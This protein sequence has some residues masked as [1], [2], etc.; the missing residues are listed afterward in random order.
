MARQA[1]GRARDMVARGGRCD[2]A[3]DGDK[4]LERDCR[5]GATASGS[6]PV[7]SR[8]VDSRPTGQAPPSRIS[9]TSSP[10]SAATCAAMVGLTRPER[11]ADG[12]AIGLAAARS[13]SCAT[14]WA[15]ARSATVSRPALA[16][17][18]NPASARRR[19]TRVSGPGQKRCAALARPRVELGERLG[20]GQTRDMHDQRVEARPAFGGEDSRD[21]ASRSSH[22][23]RART[24]S[25]SETRR[26]RPRAAGAPPARSS[27]A[28]PE[29]CCPS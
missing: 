27:P 2:L 18:D 17:S 19:S 5:R 28:S 4:L 20:F 24:R 15:G 14:G 9:A 3:E 11:L 21:C 22:R 7:R 26:A 29:E 13:N 16:S 8:T 6:P 1:A 10:N 23:R 25:R 12:A